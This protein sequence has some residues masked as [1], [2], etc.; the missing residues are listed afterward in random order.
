MYFDVLLSGIYP[1]RIFITIMLL[2]IYPV[3]LKVYVDTKPAHRCLQLC[4]SCLPKLGSNQ[5]SF[6]RSLDKLVCLGNVMLLLSH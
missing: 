1:F 2:K 4:Y 5:V 6:S 3:E